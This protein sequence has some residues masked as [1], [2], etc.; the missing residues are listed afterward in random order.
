MSCSSVFRHCANLY[1]VELCVRKQTFGPIPLA[2]ELLSAA[3]T[4]GDL[5]ND[6]RVLGVRA[7]W[8]FE[9][10]RRLALAIAS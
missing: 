5:T 10:D 4:G 6:R 3:N 1:V 9:V 8:H 7:P 2:R